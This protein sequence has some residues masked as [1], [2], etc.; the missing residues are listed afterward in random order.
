MILASPAQ[1]QHISLLKERFFHSAEAWR[2]HASGYLADPG[3]ADFHWSR[4]KNEIQTGIAPLPHC[5]FRGEELIGYAKVVE[6]VWH[7]QHYGIPSYKFAPLFSFCD[8]RETNFQLIQAAKQFLPSKPGTVTTIRL[9]AHDSTMAYVLGEAGF[10][11]VGTSVRMISA[12]KNNSKVDSS[13][14]E[15]YHNQGVMIRDCEPADIPALQ[16]LIR[17]SHRHSHFFNE[18]RYPLERS[19]EIF[20]EWIK[21]CAEGVAEKIIVAVDGQT[22][23]GFCSLLANQSLVKYIHQQIGILDFIVVDEAAQGR[24]IGKQL[25]H[26]AFD[27]FRTADFIELRTMAD[28]INAIQFY[29]KNGFFILSSDQ[30]YHYWT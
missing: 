17:R 20:A 16:D 22:L 11:H 9:D 2:R 6:S 21:K 29:Q 14:P 30:Y 3:L 24:G 27:W 1:I 8:D 7:T 10:V 28:N 23:L 19:R 26:A 12:I 4:V 25:L 15:K 13:S 5:F 18:C